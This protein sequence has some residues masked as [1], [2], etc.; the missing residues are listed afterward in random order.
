[1]TVPIPTPRH[2]LCAE[3]EGTE[4]WCPADMEWKPGADPFF[5]S[6]V[7]CGKFWQRPEVRGRWDSKISVSGGKTGSPKP[8]EIAGTV[9][10]K[11]A[12]VTKDRPAHS[13]FAADE[14]HPTNQADPMAGGKGVSGMSYTF[15][16]EHFKPRR[17]KPLARLRR[18]EC[19]KILAPNET[20]CRVCVGREIREAR[21]KETIE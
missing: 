12:A 9:S 4:F 3:A 5:C 15:N 11:G 8:L 6:H 21:E 18:C 20:K 16:I 1:M 2:V 13:S 17:R 19:N 10:L 7:G 14:H